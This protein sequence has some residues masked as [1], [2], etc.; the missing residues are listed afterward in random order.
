MK[1]TEKY[2]DFRSE[3]FLIQINY[4]LFSFIF[5]IIF[6]LESDF[7]TSRFS[8][9]LLFLSCQNQFQ[10]SFCFSVG[11][12]FGMVGNDARSE[13]RIIGQTEL[14]TDE[15]EHIRSKFGE[16]FRFMNEYIHENVLFEIIFNYF[17]HFLLW[18][19][20]FILSP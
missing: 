7:I 18:F 1:R 8:F 4:E 19:R 5:F 15:C 16:K 20:N 12:K 6:F 2:F 11:L 9:A 13:C 14:P 3:I 10:Y 17:R